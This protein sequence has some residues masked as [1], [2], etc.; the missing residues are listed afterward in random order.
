[1]TRRERF[2]AAVCGR[3]LDRVPKD[4]AGTGQTQVDWPPLTEE[5]KKLLGISGEYGGEYDKYDERILTALDID[6][7]RV[8]ELFEPQ[9]PLIRQVGGRKYD[10]WGVG[11]EF[12]GLYW[13]IVE[14]PLRGCTEKELDE[15]RFPDA[16]DIDKKLIAACAEK[17]KR[18]YNDTDYVVVAEHPCYGVFEIGCWMFG[19]DD[20]LLRMAAE[21]EIVHKFSEKILKYQLDVCGMY[22][23]ALGKYIHVTTEG[24]DFGTQNGAFMSAAMFDEMIAPYM[25]KRIALTKSLTNAKFFHHT[26]GSVFN[27]IPSLIDCGVDILNPIQPLARDMQPEKLKAAYGD[28]LAFWG[29]IDTQRLLNSAAPDEVEKEVKRVISVMGGSGYILAPSHTLQPDIIA[30]NVIRMYRCV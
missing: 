10:C 11:R 24:D 14:S 4:L 30:E 21:P 28:R 18:L 8:G 23:E 17:A 3:P 25:K 15:Y 26:C 6:F 27:L 20:Y 22:Y 12:T 1:M 16:A 29:G 9:S 2:A 19:F 5:L 7:R 13:E